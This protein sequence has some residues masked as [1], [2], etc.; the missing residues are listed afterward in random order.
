MR[1]ARIVPSTYQDVS[2]SVVAN[3]NI[4]GHEIFGLPPCVKVVTLALSE[5]SSTFA[6]EKGR[7]AHKSSERIIHLRV[8]GIQ[9]LVSLINRNQAFFY[10]L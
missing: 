2:F 1:C 9:I 4:I 8:C 7:V 6:R 10:S 5:S 3:V